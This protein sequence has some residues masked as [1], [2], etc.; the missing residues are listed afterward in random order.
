MAI[1]GFADQGLADG[2]FAVDWNSC[3]FILVPLQGLLAL[4]EI[5]LEGVWEISGDGYS[6]EGVNLIWTADGTGVA[7]KITTGREKPNEITLKMDPLTYEYVVKPAVSPPNARPRL[8]N[9]QI[10]VVDPVGVMTYSNKY[11]KCVDTGTDHNRPSDG[12]PHDGSF[13]FQPTRRG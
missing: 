5:R 2:D 10:Q 13:K 9:F 8:F 4:Q 12:T 3:R 6:R 1:G 11:L 7:R